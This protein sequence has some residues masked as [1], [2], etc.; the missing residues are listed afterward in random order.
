MTIS[1]PKETPEGES[2]AALVPEHV[3]K[4][5]KLG[6]RV[7]VEHG[8]G[9]DSGHSD[10]AYTAA[11]AALESRGAVLAGADFL[12]TVRGLPAADIP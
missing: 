4:L 9:L 8:A 1:I 11:G 6:V 5:V 3:G 10:D 2:R 12:F 7:L